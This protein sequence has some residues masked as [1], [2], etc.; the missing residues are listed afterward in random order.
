MNQL[1]FCSKRPFAFTCLLMLVSFLPFSNVAAQFNQL[2]GDNTFHIDQVA[3]LSYS[4][5]ARDFKVPPEVDGKYLH[6]CSGTEEICT[7]EAFQASF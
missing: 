3:K 7:W 4:G 5:E 6:L 2:N 1:H